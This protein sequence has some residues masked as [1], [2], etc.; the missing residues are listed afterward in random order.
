MSATLRDAVAEGERIGSAY[1][2]IPPR[3]TLAGAGG[4][5]VSRRAGGS[6]EFRDHRDYQPGDDL[7]HLDWNVLARSD[8]LT[9]KQFQEEVS[10]H[11][12]LIVDGSRSTGLEGTRKGEATMAIAALLAAAARNSGHPYTLSVAREQLTTVARGST[13][14]TDWDG[15]DFDF[16]GSPAAAIVDGA[17]SLR[18]L[19]LRVFISDLLWRG[20]PRAVL[21]ALAQGAA[22]VLVV[23]VMAQSEVAPDLRGG[24]RLIDAESGEWR[25]IVFDAA[26]AARYSDALTRHRALWD[27]AARQVRA[28]VVRGVAEEMEGQLV[29]DELGD[30]GIL[31]AS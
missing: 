9:V 5:R 23:Q 10:P 7:R 28:L 3:T 21:A 29:F 12:D 30:A 24:W 4:A 26:A 20:E 22:A 2:I 17:R 13:R 19:S 8:R 11:L 15:I 25:E 27:E 18:P 31:R 16:A 1:T 14:P 6:L